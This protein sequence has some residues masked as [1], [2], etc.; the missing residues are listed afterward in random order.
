MTDILA[1]HFSNPLNDNDIQ[2]RKYKKNN[3]RILCKIWDLIKFV[4][5]IMVTNWNQCEKVRPK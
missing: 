5:L 1:A 4:N 3:S 2:S